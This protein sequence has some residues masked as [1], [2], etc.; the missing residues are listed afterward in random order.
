MLEKKILIP[1]NVKIT[2]IFPE[3]ITIILDKKNK[4]E[5]KK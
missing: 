2:G 1:Q 5:N 4:G 3:N